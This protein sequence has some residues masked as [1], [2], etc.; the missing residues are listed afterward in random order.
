MTRDMTRD[1]TSDM[2]SDM[3]GD[4]TG[5]VTSDR[6]GATS[7]VDRRT[8]AEDGSANRQPT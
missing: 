8:G 6:G 1:M 4:V 2:T 7:S 3:T 5:D